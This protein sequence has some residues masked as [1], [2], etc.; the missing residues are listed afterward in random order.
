MKS[1]ETSTKETPTASKPISIKRTFNLPVDTVWKAFTEPESFKKWW[2]PKGFTCPSCTIDLTV[3]GKFISCMRDANGKEYWSTGKFKEIVPDKK[4][5]YSDNFSDSKGN[6]IPASDYNMPGDWSS[7]VV[8][9]LELKMQ[10][11][12]QIFR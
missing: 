1:T 9:T 10:V 7:D 2:G 5:V 8:V 11:A 3:G 6:V 4:L 12:K